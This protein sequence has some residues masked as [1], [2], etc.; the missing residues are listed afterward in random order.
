LSPDTAAG[1]AMLCSAL[2]SPETTCESVDCTPALDDV[3]VAWATV[4]AW[5]AV[6]AALVVSGGEPNGVT[7]AA[8]AE[9]P[10]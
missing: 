8:A 5:L 3:P 2:G 6:P 1:D 4:P 10:A 7:V 9:A